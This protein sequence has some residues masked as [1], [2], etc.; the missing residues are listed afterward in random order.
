MLESI[1]N[2][3]HRYLD[4]PHQKG[5]NEAEGFYLLQV[6]EN[7]EVWVRELNPGVVMRSVIAP[8][9]RLKNG[10]DFMIYL[11]KANFLGQGTGGSVISLDM[12]EKFLSFSLCLGY[13]INYKTF[14]DALEDFVNYLDF[15]R[16]ELK[17][18]ETLDK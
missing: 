16:S 11:S 2:D 1:L 7:I 3:L 17:R 6:P 15:W 10:E 4:F 8:I 5:A 14:R 13:D 12:E 18:L 9:P